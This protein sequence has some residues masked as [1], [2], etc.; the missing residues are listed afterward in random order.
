M[1]FAEARPP[2]FID[3]EKAEFDYRIAE[4]AS[5]RY[6]LFCMRCHNVGGEPDQPELIAAAYLLMNVM[7]MSRSRRK[8]LKLATIGAADD[9]SRYAHTNILRE[10]LNGDFSSLA[11]IEAWHRI[12]AGR[13][14]IP[15][16]IFLEV[17]KAVEFFEG[18]EIA[19]SASEFHRAHVYLGMEGFG[20][21]DIM[22]GQFSLDMKNAYQPVI[23]GRKGRYPVR[24]NSAFTADGVTIRTGN[25][26]QNVLVELDCSIL[27]TGVRNWMSNI[28]RILNLDFYRAGIA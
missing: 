13:T 25:R 23:H 26:G 7:L 6:N 11:N 28:E 4:L 9:T 27:L 3:T 1:E 24:L 10:L 15:E 21:D 16:S 8:I 14:E 12:L 17:E 5:G 2:L 18:A 20:V 22:G 19:S